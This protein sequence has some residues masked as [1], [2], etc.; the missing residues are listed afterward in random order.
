ML[1]VELN[2]E[3]HEIIQK[4]KTK[5]SVNISQLVKNFFR[6]YIKKVEKTN[7]NLDVQIKS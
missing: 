1:N 5:Y 7:V 6:E 2:E 3:E 4:L